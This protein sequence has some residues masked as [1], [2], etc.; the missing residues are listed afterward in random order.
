MKIGATSNSAQRCKARPHDAFACVGG[1]AP[2]HSWVMSSVMFS[3]REPPAVG[4]LVMHEVE[5]P[6]GVDPGQELTM[7]LHDVKSGIGPKHNIGTWYLWSDFRSKVDIDDVVYER[8]AQ[9][10]SDHC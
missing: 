7:C 3:T 9:Y 4:H 5:R 10:K 6:S 8:L 1:I 2:K